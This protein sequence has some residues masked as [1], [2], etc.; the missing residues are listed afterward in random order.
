[1]TLHSSAVRA[2]RSSA[3]TGTTAVVVGALAGTVAWA[4]L[5]AAMNG[6]TQPGLGGQGSHPL[7]A[8]A[9]LIASLLGG[10]LGWATLVVVERVLHR[11]RRTWL[12]I[13]SAALILSFGGPLSGTEV[14]V[15]DRLALIFLHVTVAAVVVPLL[16]RSTGAQPDR[17]EPL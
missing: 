17:A 5:D 14:T 13:V 7:E 9:V 10:L 3:T 12:A 4:I 15:G 11:D 6:L 1:V 2:R 8:G 16:Y